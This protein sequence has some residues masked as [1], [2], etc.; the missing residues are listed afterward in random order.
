MHVRSHASHAKAWDSVLKFLHSMYKD[1]C[2]Y[3]GLYAARSALA[4][5]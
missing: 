1:G 5:W 3:S 4:V 2:L